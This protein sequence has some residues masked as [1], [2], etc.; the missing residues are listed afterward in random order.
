MDIDVE[1]DIH[2]QARTQP[3]LRFPI[4]KGKNQLP[5]QLL[6]SRSIPTLYY[7]HNPG[8]SGHLICH[9]PQLLTLTTLVNDLSLNATSAKFQPNGVNSVSQ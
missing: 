8:G 4:N 7:Q 2:T 9:F 3:T 5:N 1:E 6:N